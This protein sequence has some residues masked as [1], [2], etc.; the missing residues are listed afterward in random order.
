MQMHGCALLRSKFTRLD[1]GIAGVQTRFAGF[2]MDIGLGSEVVVGL[3]SHPNLL[4]GSAI[5]SDSTLISADF[6]GRSFK[7]LWRD[8]RDGF[9]GSVM[10][11]RK[12]RAN[13]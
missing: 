13:L 10:S 11:L 1:I 8:S 2:E 6:H 7:P 9:Q 5:I 4:F 12:T 3:S